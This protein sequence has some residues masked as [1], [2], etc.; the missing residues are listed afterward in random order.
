MTVPLVREAWGL[1]D[2]TTEEFVV[3]VCG[4]KFDFVSG[5]PGCVGD[6]Y[7]LQMDRVQHQ[8]SLSESTAFYSR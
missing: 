5:G 1:G 7:I 4:V 6:L 2:E 8:W 3:F